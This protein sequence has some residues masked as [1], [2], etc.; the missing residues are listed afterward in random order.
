MD[1]ALELRHGCEEVGAEEAADGGEAEPREADR[2]R[3]TA[4]RA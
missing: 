1:L 4:V 2:E 3:S